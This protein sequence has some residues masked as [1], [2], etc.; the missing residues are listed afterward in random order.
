[1]SLVEQS[2]SLIKGTH[3]KI[4][5]EVNLGQGRQNLEKKIMNSSLKKPCDKLPKT[6]EKQEG[7]LKFDFYTTAQTNTFALFDNSHRWS[8]DLGGRA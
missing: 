4:L 1:M 3:R 7:Q 2:S 6:K 5:K 8:F